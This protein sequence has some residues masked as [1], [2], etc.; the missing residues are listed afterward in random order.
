[1]VSADAPERTARA[2]RT[3]VGGLADVF[4]KVV[5]D[6]DIIDRARKEVAAAG[7]IPRF[8]DTG[9]RFGGGDTHRIYGVAHNVIA[10]DQVVNRAARTSAILVLGV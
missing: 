1:M 3:V 2:T 8:S 4:E 5:V 6:V 9:S 10:E 7:S